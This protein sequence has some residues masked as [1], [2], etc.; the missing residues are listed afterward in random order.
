MTVGELVAKLQ[1]FDQTLSV[2]I[3]DDCCEP[4]GVCPELQY[5]SGGVLYQD[6]SDLEE[7]FTSREVVAL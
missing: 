2:Y 7:G 1:T 6:K 4:A 3:C 5:L